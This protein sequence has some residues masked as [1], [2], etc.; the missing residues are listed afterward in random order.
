MLQ[1]ASASGGAAASSADSIVGPYQ[2]LITNTAANLQGI[3]NTWANVTAPAL[4][5][6]FTQTNPQLIISALA[7][8]NP[9]SI[10]SGT[11][12]GSATLIQALTV[13]AS[14]SMTAFN[15]PTASLA[16]GLGLPQLL[17]FDA[18]GA[19]VNAALAASASSRAILDAV[20]TGNSLAAATAFVDAPANIAN[21]FLNGEQTLPMRL[22]LPGQPLTADVPFGGLL[23]PLQPFTTTA[24]LPGNPLLQTVTITGPPVGGLVPALLEYTP[25]LLTSAFGA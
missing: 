10:V 5:R 1:S 2:S 18:L 13:P 24:A 22:P 4:L 19:P 8:G 21:A 20:Q 15:P 7:N 25:Q 6:T 12:Q 16:V 9:L 3:G 11:A 23:V 14:V 17:A